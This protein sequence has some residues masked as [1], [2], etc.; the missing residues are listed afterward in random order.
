MVNKQ[1][2]PAYQKLAYDFLSTPPETALRLVME[3]LTIHPYRISHFNTSAARLAVWAEKGYDANATREFLEVS[4]QTAGE[5]PAGRKDD[6]LSSGIQQSKTLSGTAGGGVR[7]AARPVLHWA[8]D[9]GPWV[10]FGRQCVSSEKGVFSHSQ[11]PTLP[12]FQTLLRRVYMKRKGEELRISC[13]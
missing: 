5:D 10:R 8:W 2:D 7:R 13:S 12:H 3:S 4:L 9:A 1:A 6:G 11:T